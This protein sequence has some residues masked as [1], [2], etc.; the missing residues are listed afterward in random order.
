MNNLMI[1]EGRQVEVFELN[2]LVLF[3]PY[4]VAECLDIKNVRD[5]IVKMNEKQ[6]V[7]LTNS[8]VGITDFRKLH[9]TGEN[10][11]T[12]SGVYKLIFKSH[13]PD[14]EKFQDWVTDEV[15]PTIRKTGSYTAPQSKPKR[16]ALGSV[17]VA[18]KNIMTVYQAAGVDPRFTA[19]AV[20]KLYEEMAD[21]KLIPPI[22]VE[23]AEMIYDKTTIAKLL[24]II[25]TVSNLPHASAIGAIISKIDVADNEMIKVQYS[26]RGHS[27]FD[28]Q[29]KQ[30]V[31]EKIKRW[32]K[33][34]NYPVKIEN[35]GKSYAVK[36]LQVA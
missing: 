28:F 10:F 14:A 12:E 35:N 30:S 16:P 8:N 20:T 32:L 26:R 24:G 11:L 25:S 7:K 18:A 2:G 27:G 29:F 4:H 19:T 1:F 3:N 34:N 36:Y 13:K 15:L 23:P 5:N 6:V 9:N 21:I 31:I 22:Q 17:N 33:D